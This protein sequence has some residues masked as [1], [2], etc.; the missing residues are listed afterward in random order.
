MIV[1]YLDRIGRRLDAVE[2]PGT[3]GRAIEEASGYL[4]DLSDPN[5]LAAASAAQYSI[6]ASPSR[7]LWPECYG[8]TLSESP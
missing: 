4:Y 1:D 2:V 3:T 6:A 5:R 8:V 7:A